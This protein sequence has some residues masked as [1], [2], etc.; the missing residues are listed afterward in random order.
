MKTADAVAQ[1]LKRE[2]VEFLIGYPVNPII[3]A[4]ARADIRTIIVRQERI[5]LHMAD[6]VSRVTSAD[7]IGIFAMQS[8]PGTENAFGGVAQAYGDSVPIMVLPGGYGRRINQYPPNFSAFLNFRNITKWIEQVPEAEFVPD[9]MR[10]AFTQVRNGR[11]RPVLVEF[12][13]DIM[14]DEVPEPLKYRPAPRMRSG[15]DPADVARAAEMLVTAER[16]VIYAGQGVHYARAWQSLRALAELLEAPVT[17]SLEGKSAFPENHPLYLGCG[18][19]AYPEAVRSFLDRSD[20]VFGIGCSFATT[21]FG[22]KMPAVDGVRKFIHATL[23]PTDI[24]KDVECDQAVIGDAQL[25]LDALLVEVKDRLKGKTRGRTVGLTAEIKSINDAWLHKWLPK[26]TFDGSPL[27]PYRVIWDMLHTV[28]VAN[29]IITH[30]AGSPRDQLSPFW[31]STEPLSYVGWGKTT[32]LGTGLGLMMGAK[33][34]KPDKLCINVWG[35]AAIGFTGMDFETAVRERI[36]ILSILLNNFSMA[37]ELKV[38]PI[39]TEKYRSTDISG[40]YAAMARAFGGYGERV[41]EPGEIKAA[42]RR[43]IEQT[44]AGKPALLE[45]ITAKETR[46]SK[47]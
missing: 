6:A 4:A 3:E 10:R 34:A 22:V 32:Q 13:G 9:I 45:F 19:R 46:V 14:A 37:I 40:D 11:P 18:G 33:L 5:G 31:Q 15:P 8:G 38:M 30:D 42:I 27:N 23:D 7:R 44:Q 21:A 12:P 20:V 47:F 17:T 2:G 29:T 25:I 36:P 24:N 41:T 39:S 43:G 16:P 35:D 28:D 26:L 1:I